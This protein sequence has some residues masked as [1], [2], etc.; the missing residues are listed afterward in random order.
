LANMNLE[1]PGKLNPH[2]VP[3]L[4][5]RSVE[6]ARTALED[7]DADKAI[8]MMLSTDKLCC[9][10]VAP[11]TV[12]GIALRVLSDAYLKKGDTAEAKRALERGLALCKVHDGKAGMPAFMAA[13]L[14]GRMGDLLAALGEI[15]R[16]EGEHK[17]AVR[18][19]RLAA[20]RF[21]SMGQ[22]DFTAATFNRIAVCL[23]EQGDHKQALVELEESER[24]GAGAEHE[25][26]L[27]SS[28]FLH[29]ANCL[30]ATGDTAGAREAMSKAL[31]YALAC[32]NDGAVEE[33]QAF[34]GKTQGASTVDQDAFL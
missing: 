11:P 21:L 29:R 17:L 30:E 13:D 33:A 10:V 31:Q 6:N 28:T 5:M 12:H 19:L 1:T 7:G 23:M 25:A 18:H 15:N 8:K 34:L 9:K 20:E 26:A 32:G 3:Q 4:V 2:Q 16:G 22:T 27:Y 24:L 14:N